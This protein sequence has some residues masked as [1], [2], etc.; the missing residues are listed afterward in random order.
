MGMEAGECR[1]H[2]YRGPDRE[3]QRW[4]ERGRGQA[5]SAIGVTVEVL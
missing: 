1:G 3:E 5:Q 2:K 4:G